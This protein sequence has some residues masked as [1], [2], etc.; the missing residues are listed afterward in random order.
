M[1]HRIRESKSVLVLTD[2]AHD[3]VAQPMI[4]GMVKN[5][6]VLLRPKL[7]TT[8]AMTG[9]PIK[10]PSGINAA[11]H[12][13][14]SSVTRKSYWSSI[15]IGPAG[16]VHPSVVPMMNPEMVTIYTGRLYLNTHVMRQR[17]IGAKKVTL[18]PIKTH[19]WRV[20]KTHRLLLPG[21]ECPSAAL[22][23]RG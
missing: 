1:S 12:E 5:A 14:F 18:L 15:I 23:C 10:A 6:M 8:T 7:S 11:I 9:Q 17:L 21:I 19:F 16:D 22:V 20:A 2:R 3:I 4:V 13:T